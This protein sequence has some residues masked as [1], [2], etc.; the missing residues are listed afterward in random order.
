MRRVLISIITINLLCTPIYALDFDTSVDDD[1]RKNYNPSKL[2]KEMALPMLP[3][4][5]DEG[6]E[7][8]YQPVKSTSVV[9][10]P[11]YSAK[12]QQKAIVQPVQSQPQ[13]YKPTYQNNVV[14]TAPRVADNSY[15]VLKKGTKIRVKL[16]NDISDRSKRGAKI[17]FI[18]RYPVST[19]CYTI[20]M[21]T[22]FHGEIANVHRPQLSGNGGLLVLNVNSFDVNGSS[23]PFIASIT[24]A[25][26]KKVFFNNIKG[27]RKYMKS[28]GKTMKPGTH[29]FHKMMTVTG[30]L[31]SDGSSVILTPF[32]LAAGF[33]ALGANIVAAPILAL[34]YKGDG[35]Y[36]HEGSDFEI[37]LLQDVFIYN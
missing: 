33:A 8:S 21:G 18:S 30:S 11:Q 7:K 29:F 4:N 20:P 9:P 12:V 26:Y 15:A 35:I 3:K 19:T 6:V 14:Q 1:I 27:K 28:L 25:N 23:Q 36:I 16:L 17:S 24:K 32:S 31:A 22:I 34:F 37:M 2:E 10:Q 13:Y 5:F